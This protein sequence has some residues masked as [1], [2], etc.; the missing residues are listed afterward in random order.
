RDQTAIEWKEAGPIYR[1]PVNAAICNPKPGT[2]FSLDRIRIA[3]YALPTGISGNTIRHVSVSVDGAKTWHKA[4]LLNPP[5]DFCWNLWS[6]DLKVNE[7]TTEIWAR[8]E[9]SS[10]N[11]MPARVPWNA[12][13]YLQNSW[14]KTK[15]KVKS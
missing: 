6:I 1:F 9:D 3:G 10:G 2:V 14:Y 12:K 15:I 8:A 4:K 11:F 5:N 7:S 13:G